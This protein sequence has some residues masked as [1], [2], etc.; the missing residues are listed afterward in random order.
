MAMNG[1]VHQDGQ[2][3][4]PVALAVT[5][6]GTTI[7]PISTNALITD[8]SGMKYLVAIAKFIYGSSGTTAKVFV[9]TTLDNGSTW[10]DIMCLA[11]T[12]AS[13]TK[14]SAVTANIAP[15]AQAF[16]PTDGSMTDN[17]VI[18]GVLGSA[19]RIKV[20]T[21]GTYAGDTQL[22]VSINAKG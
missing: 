19:V 7:Y 10:V 18:N 13:L 9:Q 21:A 17:T 11:F 20:I 2:Y 14:I 15:A 12:T 5:T 16:S 4:E 3:A 1:A 22:Y 6:A 8:L